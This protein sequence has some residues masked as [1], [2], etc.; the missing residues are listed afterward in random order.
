L[1]KRGSINDKWQMEDEQWKMLRRSLMKRRAFLYSLPSVYL[2]A[3]G[4]AFGQKVC[5]FDILG[6]WRTT[7]YDNA[8]AL[9]YRFAPDGTITV[10]SHSGSGQTEI[11]GAAYKLDNSRKTILIATTGNVGGFEK[12][13]T[14]LKITGYDDASFTCE[15]P[16]SGAMRWV[17]VE[18]HR[19]FLV[20]AGR[21]G[22]F[23]D[24]SG[25]TFP[26]LIK[27]GGKQPQ[28]DAV[29]IYSSGGHGAFGKIPADTCNEFMK[30]PRNSSD[31][32]LRLEMTEAEYERSL[33]IVRTWERR[34]REGAL[35]YPN[36][37]LDNILLVKQVTEGLNRCGQKIKLYNLDWGLEDT[38]SEHNAPSLAP[39]LYFKELRRLNESLHVRD[40]KFKDSLVSLKSTH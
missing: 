24:H 27:T 34:A 3:Q 12:G 26:M 17:R 38:I 16:G 4:T 15:K 28:I 22:T 23:Y 32:M 36:I 14:T 8:D 21:S 6:T 5:E 19:Y 18:S 9:L 39:F 11:G 31:V 10:L 1:K 25:P 7:G 29:G 30:E 20:L 35:L 40:K 2:A 13:T 33:H 37:Y